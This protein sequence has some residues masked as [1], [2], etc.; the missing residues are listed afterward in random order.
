MKK[1][2]AY[3]LE[4][5]AL[6]LKRAIIKCANLWGLEREII[7]AWQQGL[8]QPPRWF[9]IFGTL[10]ITLSYVALVLLA[11]LGMFLA[12]PADRR[13]HL[14]CLLLVAFISGLHT[15]TFGHS[16]YHLPFI[17]LL[18]LYAAAAVHNQSWWC[19]REGFRQAAAPIA[20]WV[21]LGAIWGR[22]VL[23]I[24]TNRIRDFLRVLLH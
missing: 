24:D 1:A 21:S 4:Q 12:R 5:P 10:A 23:L 22:E 15:I 20:V 16:R 14:F 6:T 2:L 17:P 18:L 11:S 13:A 19:F 7:A 3:M 8:Y 9:V